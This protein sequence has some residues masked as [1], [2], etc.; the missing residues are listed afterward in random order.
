MINVRSLQALRAVVVAGSVTQAA[1]TLNISQ[2]AVSRMIADLEQELGFALFTRHRG[3]LAITPQ[4]EAFYSE[5]ARALAG[6]DEVSMVGRQIKN[7]AGTTLRLFSMSSAV[8]D[9]LPRALMEFRKSYPAVSVNLEIRGGREV[10]HWGPGRQ[11][12]LGIVVVPAAHKLRGLRPFLKVEAYVVMPP[13]HRLARE[14]SVSLAQLADEELVM[15]PSTSIIRRWLDGEFAQIRTAPRVVLE[16]SSMMSASHYAAMGVGLTIADP[17]AI[18]AISHGE[19]VVRPLAPELEFT[20]C[21]VL[22]PDQ[23]PTPIVS[24]FMAVVETVATALLPEILPHR[25]C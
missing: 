11:F 7:G 15:M 21:F 9:I 13:R 8:N 4:G 6:L 18:H 23:L 16:T 14:A 12:D 10:T 19:F 20:F 1:E 2:P 25:P 24:H 5:T 17:F 3:R 22:P